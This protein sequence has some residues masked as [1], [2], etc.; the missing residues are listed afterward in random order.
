MNSHSKPICF[1]S[2]EDLSGYFTYDERTANILSNN[3]LPVE[4]IPWRSNVDWNRFSL[5][6]IRS[7]WDYQNNVE[8]F[9]QVLEAIHKSSAV[10]IN[11]LNVVRWNLNKGYLLQLD[12]LGVPIIPTFFGSSPTLIDLNRFHQEL[13]GNELILKPLVGANAEGIFRLSPP[14]DSPL[15]KQAI[16]H[17]NGRDFFAQPFL[18]SIETEGETSIIYFD[19][20]FNHAI[21]KRPKKGDF[22][23]QEEHGGVFELCTPDAES[24]RIA[25][26][27]LKA[28][29]E[30]LQFKEPLL[31]ARVD[32]ARCLNG[33]LGL[34]ELELIEPSLYLNLDEESP[35]RFAEAIIRAREKYVSTSSTQS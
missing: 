12:K 22:R 5:V 20:T 16:N 9:L 27:A 1:L 29:A 15:A 11:P 18:P 34:M 32:L 30:V 4:F 35:Q 7:T 25:E 31:Y 33:S 28:V 19:G 24:L 8:S 17:Y 2:M 10:L 3:G 6:L 26:L 13:G 23:V 14:F 21:I